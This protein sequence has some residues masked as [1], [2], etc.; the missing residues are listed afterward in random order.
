MAEISTAAAAAEEMVVVKERVPAVVV[1]VT[2]PI[3]NLAGLSP[4]SSA[5][6]MGSGLQNVSFP[7][8]YYVWERG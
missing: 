3:T 7:R 8:E 4:P 2:T 6:V 5:A 1:V